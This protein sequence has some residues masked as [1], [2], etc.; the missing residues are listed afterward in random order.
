MLWDEAVRVLGGRPGTA[1]D[2]VDR[3]A[4]GHRR[5]HDARHVLAVVRHV[6]DL[7]A[8]RADQERAVL[9]L[10]A[11]AHDVVYD[12]E[13]GEDERRSAA[14]V[15]ERLAAAGVDGRRVAA[16]VLATADHRA[17][18]ELTG[19]LLDADLAVLAAEPDDYER[20]RLAVR[21]EYAH[22]PEDAWRV[23]RGRVLRGLLE[24]DPLYVTPRAR[25]RWESR[26]K[27]NL[28]AELAT[29]SDRP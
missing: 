16:L 5:Y 12:G 11:L 8:H 17:A 19:L 27:A 1:G 4:E 29:L 15:G 6:T 2:L 18:D 26:A 13:P 14:W 25:D 10:A 7:A 23:G 21:A 20:Y 3:Y 28:A 24:R 22:V 9:V